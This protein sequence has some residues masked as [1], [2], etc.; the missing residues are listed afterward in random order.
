MK[1][2]IPQLVVVAVAVAGICAASTAGAAPAAKHAP[3]RLAGPSYTA[4]ELQA[5]IAFGNASFA[6]QKALIAHAARP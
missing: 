2:R 6:E 1:H 4:A 3:P 5:L